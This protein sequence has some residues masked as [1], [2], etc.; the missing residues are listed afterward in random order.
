VYPDKRT[1]SEPDR[2][3]RLGTP[4]D[5]R[6]DYSAPVA[7]VI[8]QA[9]RDDPLKTWWRTSPSADFAPHSISAESSG[10]NHISHT[11]GSARLVRAKGHVFAA[12]LVW[13]LP[14][15]LPK[16]PAQMRLIRKADAQR[17]FT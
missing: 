5:I 3:S 14:K 2:T 7:G 1:I 11:C 4:P 6:G 10:S 15:G 9:T 17:Y 13:T 16:K 8:E 12:P